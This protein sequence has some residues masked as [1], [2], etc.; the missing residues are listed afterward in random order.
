MR[1]DNAQSYQELECSNK[2]TG[3][4]RT[5]N[6]QV[7]SLQVTC[8]YVSVEGSLPEEHEAMM[9]TKR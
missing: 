9:N 5:R 1:E 4:G 8:V 3:E 7:A 6:D 2:G